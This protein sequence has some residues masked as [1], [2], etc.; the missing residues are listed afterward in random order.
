MIKYIWH[1]II[2]IIISLI[3]IL[4]INFF[5]LYLMPGSPF[6]NP[7]LTS[8][9]RERMEER[10]GLNDPILVQYGRYMYRVTKLDFGGT[11]ASNTYKD[12][13]RDYI[14]E[15]VPL[16][17]QIGLTALTIGTV[18]GITLGA[19]AAIK[20]NTAID[21]ILTAVGVLGVSIPSFVFAAFLQQIFAINN[22][23]LPLTF[24]RA[25]P[26]LGYTLLDQYKGLIMPIIALSVGPI[27]SIMRYMRTELVEVLNTDYILLARSKGLSKTSVIIKHALR[28]AL[29]PVITILG[30]MSIG[31]ITGTLVIEQFFSIPG[32][33]MNLVNFTQSKETYA[34][35]GINFFYSLMYVVVILFVDIL[36]GIIDPRIRIAKNTKEGFI[37]KFFRKIAVKMKTKFN[38]GD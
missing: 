22:Q 18:I 5:F 3:L 38:W 6:T 32:L 33:A 31:L 2:L 23:I 34:T 37:L 10:Y 27:A 30:P 12:I 17:A 13:Y 28:N 20:R 4:S 24:T 25:D 14:R 26:E 7:K 29:I 8:D 15:R 21:N 35:L 9:Q 11:I 16:T 1:R 36:Y 19:I